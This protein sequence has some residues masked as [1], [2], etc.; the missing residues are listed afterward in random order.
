MTLP[1]SHSVASPQVGGEGGIVSTI[2]LA[3]NRVL[4]GNTQ[5]AVQDLPGDAVFDPVNGNVYVRG[6][7][8]SA[9][10]VV[11][12]PSNV[13]VA[14]VSTWAAG[15]TYAIAPTMAVDP[16]SGDLYSTSSYGQNVTVINATSNQV[17]R[18]IFV[19]GSPDSLAYDPSNRL[20]YISNWGGNNVTVVSAKTQKVVGNV[21]VG[22]H[23]S[24]I[25]Y[26]P[27][28]AHVYVANYFSN[29]VTIINAT[30]WRVE[31]N[32]PVGT[33]PIALGLDTVNDY[34]DVANFN[35]GAAS[36]V[37]VIRGAT[38]ALQGV[39]GVGGG[40]LSF[41][42]Y[43]PK[44]WMY[45]AN[46]VSGNISVLNQST[47]KVT[48]SV[49]TGVAPFSVRFD[50]VNGNM[51]VDNAQ[52]P[53]ITFVRASDHRIIGGLMTSDGLAYGLAVDTNDGNVYAVSQGSYTGGGPP[54]HLAANL[55]GISG[56]TGLPIA[57][58]PL[59]VYPTGITY[60]AADGF[61][62]VVNPGGD[63]IYLVNATTGQ[64]AGT[65]PVG[66]RPQWTSYDPATRELWVV[67]QAGANITVLDSALH[68]VASVPTG[69]SPTGIA[70]DAAD[71]EMYVSDNLAGN[72][73]VINATTHSV[74]TSV[75]IKPFENLYSVGYD[76]HNHEVYVADLSGNNV[77]AI[78]GTTKV[79]S[80]RVGNAPESF[81]Y[82][83][84][85]HTE[86]VANS[87]SG[88]VSVLN[89]TTN[90]IVAT[91]ADPYAG[92][93]SYDPTNNA[94]YSAG[95][96]EG[97]V[98]AANASTY[99]SLGTGLNT[100]TAQYPSG[101]TYAPS[102]GD[103]YVTTQYAGSVSVISPR[104]SPTAYPVTFVESGLPGGTSW[105]VTLNGTPKSSLTNTTLFN[106]PNG[107]YGFTVGTVAGYV[108]NVSSGTVHVL[109][110]RQS[111][112]IGFTGTGGSNSNFPVTFTQHG[113]PQGTPWS[114]TFVGL[115]NGSTLGSIVFSASN[116]SHAFSVGAVAGFGATPASGAVI[117]AGRPAFQNITFTAG[118][119][120]LTAALTAV[121]STVTLGGS[122]Q[123]ETTAG[124]G[125]LPLTYQYTGLPSGCVSANSTT[126]PCTATATGRFNVS[127]IVTDP[128]GGRAEANTT[129]TVENHSGPTSSSGVSSFSILLLLI[130]ILVVV[131]ILIAVLRSRRRQP[132]PSPPVVGP[133]PAPSVPPGPPAP[134]VG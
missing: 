107:S 57:A 33:Y 77:T 68:P 48:A 35:N 128:I 91:Y 2:D 12:T 53:N 69:I 105:S 65:A 102:T 14:T 109:G 86:F 71:G 30:D 22:T 125:S 42:F 94:V 89:D 27:N 85:N 110:A 117:V 92:F 114:V 93:L 116:G 82:D 73:S 100:G 72:V 19:G 103:V 60:D 23:P 130:L 40:P 21:A 101:I 132:P 31:A 9:I 120:P 8:N 59:L 88:N 16:V 54:P 70:Y 43:A 97:V 66:L 13:L 56:S 26:D 25:L 115:T 11:H 24:A 121:P 49:T 123:L 80:T 41:A 95:N 17:V 61:L 96:F 39:V 62:I 7:V 129:L 18:N 63:D 51:Y 76:P 131:A 108:A 98:G 112:A 20:F 74:V 124:G 15:E 50:A 64:V 118:T 75:L 47:G 87:G 34:I 38:G 32:L 119:S 36:N 134:P 90:Q 37:T 4:P 46:E 81:A 28:T 67:D 84:R 10:S 104:G 122:T 127:V 44:D 78:L 3:D 83:P 1:G 52:T 79:A 106:E 111:V 99:A 6:G 113:L 58:V 126:L 5:P 55:T 133:P 45:I 29:N